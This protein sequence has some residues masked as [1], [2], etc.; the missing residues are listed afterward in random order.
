M[1]QKHFQKKVHTHMQ[2]KNTHTTRTQ[3]NERQPNRILFS[4]TQFL[5]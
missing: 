1:L 5:S 4:I 2:A 3:A